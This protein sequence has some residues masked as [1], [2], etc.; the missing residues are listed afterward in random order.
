M[1]HGFITIRCQDAR[2]AA[3]AYVGRLSDILPRE[4]PETAMASR[5][6]RAFQLLSD[7]TPV[8]VNVASPLIDFIR[9]QEL[10]QI[11]G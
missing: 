8:T 5:M 3:K 1:D 4:H 9:S 7:D 10:P 6:L 2:R 11:N